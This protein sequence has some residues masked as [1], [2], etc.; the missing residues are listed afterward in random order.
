MGGPPFSV[1][2]SHS[3]AVLPGT[4]SQK[5]HLPSNS[6][7]RSTSGGS[8]PT[9]RPILDC[10]VHLFLSASVLHTSARYTVR[11]PRG[12]QLSCA[13]PSHGQ[14]SSTQSCI[15]GQGSVAPA[16]DETVETLGKQNGTVGR[17][18]WTPAGLGRCLADPSSRSL[19]WWMNS[20]WLSCHGCRGDNP[21]G[22]QQENRSHTGDAPAGL[23]LLS[24]CAHRLPGG[25]LNA[26]NPEP[27][28]H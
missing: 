6:C 5:S 21:C 26:G 4:T 16:P 28:V 7:L 23:L 24:S 19:P 15:V 27:P 2:L 8:E 14:V 18:S 9:T 17:M 3:S 11:W 12:T 25:A 1:S 13:L 10:P 20:K 22:V